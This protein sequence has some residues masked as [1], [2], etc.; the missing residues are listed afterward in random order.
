MSCTHQYA[1]VSI[2]DDTLHGAFCF[3][4]ASRVGQTAIQLAFG[5]QPLLTQTNFY[6]L[7]LFVIHLIIFF[8]GRLVTMQGRERRQGGHVTSSL[9]RIFM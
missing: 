4:L 9:L 7:Q 5:L 8:H 6:A 3:N 1:N 2:K